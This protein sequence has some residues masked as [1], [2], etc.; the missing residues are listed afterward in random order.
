ML[1]LKRKWLVLT[2]ILI[3]VIVSVVVWHHYRSSSS[4]GQSQDPSLTTVTESAVISKS[5]YNSVDVLGTVVSPNS[6]MLVAEQSGRVSAVHFKPGDTV[7]KGQVL[8]NLADQQQQAEVLKA[9]A[10]LIGAQVDY[11]RYLKLDQKDPEAISKDELDTKLSQLDQDKAELKLQQ[12]VLAQMAIKAPFNGVMSAPVAVNTGQY[13][14][15]IAPGAYLEAGDAV[16][17][18]TDQ[19]HSVVKYQI[20]QQDLS[21]LKLGQG[22]KLSRTTL[23]HQKTITGKVVYIAP[24]VIESTQG[25][26][27]RAL[28]DNPDG[29]LKAGMTVDV[30]QQL[31]QQHRLLVPG[32]N[33]IPSIKGYSVYKVKSG[34]VV[35][36]PV[37]VGKRYG[38]DVVILK[39]LSQTDKIITSDVG[40][41]HPGQAIKVQ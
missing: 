35:A 36:T 2:I 10:N 22:V 9:K 15:E 26:M 23:A 6:V 28:I 40:L 5:I 17:L 37:T 3:L 38:S 39:G 13:T 24:Q 20:P 4:H 33:L 34:K 12:A 30:S 8:L 21:Q 32:I 16:A 11:N 29:L 25:I 31:Q 27:V 19:N 18:I 41:L 14:T 7:S 1:R